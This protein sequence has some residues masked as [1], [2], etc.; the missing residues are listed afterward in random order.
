MA[1]PFPRMLRRRFPRRFDTNYMNSLSR[2]P[3]TQYFKF[4][5]DAITTSA[6]RRPE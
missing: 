1:A 4:P 3:T 2:T 5:I 6:S